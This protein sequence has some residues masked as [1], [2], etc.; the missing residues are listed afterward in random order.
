[1]RRTYPIP[2]LLTLILSV[3]CASSP[4][5]F[6]INEVSDGIYIKHSE[7]NEWSRT[8]HVKSEASVGEAGM[9]MKYALFGIPGVNAVY[10][11]PYCFVIHISPI[12][13]W[14]DIEP[15]IISRIHKLMEAYKEGVAEAQRQKQSL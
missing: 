11:S 12:Y 3:S 5:L 15:E 8:Y 4:N 13:S 6:I 10:P 2:L 9:L 7:V 1:M 14:E